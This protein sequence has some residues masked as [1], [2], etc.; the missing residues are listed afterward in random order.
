MEWEEAKEKAAN[1][2]PLDKRAYVVWVDGI[3]SLIEAGDKEIALQKSMRQNL[4]TEIMELNKEI[5]KIRSTHQRKVIEAEI[6]SRQQA[7]KEAAKVADKCEY[8][9]ACNMDIAK[10]ILAL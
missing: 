5:A 9:S 6:R 10:E 3:S 8:M 1:T 2:M 7:L 4:D